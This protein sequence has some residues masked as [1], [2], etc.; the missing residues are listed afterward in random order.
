[1][2]IFMVCHEELLLILWLDNTIF[3]YA[4]IKNV[5]MQSLISPAG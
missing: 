3:E 5:G 1:M 2:M 4:G